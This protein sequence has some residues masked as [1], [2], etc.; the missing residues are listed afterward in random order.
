MVSMVQRQFCNL[1]MGMR[2]QLLDVLWLISNFAFYTWEKKEVFFW[3]FDYCTWRSTIHINFFIC[4]RN[5]YFREALY[6]L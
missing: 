2:S 5:C 3:L 6:F 4:N 1:F